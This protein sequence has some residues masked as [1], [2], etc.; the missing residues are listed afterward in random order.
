MSF[1]HLN[2]VMFDIET[3]GKTPGSIVLSIGACRFNI[4]Q[5]RIYDEFSV[6]IDIYDSLK[7]GLTYDKETL[8]WWRNQNPAT[9][10][11]IQKDAKSAAEALNLFYDYLAKKQDEP[12]W[13]LGPHF[14]VPIIQMAMLKVLGIKKVPWKYYNVYDVR[15]VCNVFGVSVKRDEGVHHNSLDD[16]IAQAKFIVN[17]FTSIPE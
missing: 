2:G 7:Y 14:D 4:E 8:D 17:F 1:N 12:L 13:A 10:R 3:L 6:N 9:F 15:T 11:G 5:K 16:A